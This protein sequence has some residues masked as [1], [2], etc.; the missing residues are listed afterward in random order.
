MIRDQAG[1]VTNA[2][3]AV[4]AGAGIKVVRIQP[5]PSGLRLSAFRMAPFHYSRFTV[6]CQPT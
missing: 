2:F 5:R 6:R 4:F 1:K 3:D